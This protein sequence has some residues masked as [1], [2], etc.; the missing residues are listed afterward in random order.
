[1]GILVTC[2]LTYYGMTSV[3]YSQSELSKELQDMKNSLKESQSQINTL[4][5]QVES[6]KA[7][8]AISKVKEDHLLSLVDPWERCLRFSYKTDCKTDQ[9]LPCVPDILAE[10]VL[11]LTDALKEA[12]ITY[13]LSYGTLLGAA[14]DHAIIPW[15]TDV[16]LVVEEQD[17]PTIGKKLKRI[18]KLAKSG[19][20]FFYDE[21]YPGLSRL[22]ITDQNSIF[23][24]YEKSLP[25]STPY[26]DSGY[27]YVDIY[28]AILQ[29]GY[30]NVTWGPPC[31]FREDIVMP[32]TKIHLLGREMNA[33]KDYD[34]YL[35]QIYGPDYK[36]PPPPDQRISHGWY[37][38]YCKNG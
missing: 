4:I 38:K 24:K 2:H 6:Y 35:S 17:F 1:M 30:Y 15:T 34:K 9:D 36:T 11:A 31:R 16:D 37:Q 18:S 20:Q 29:G 25:E 12:N 23:S 10:M 22:C 7:K 28:K 13:W 26:Y 21:T 3:K 5:K 19:Y 33:P 8:L 14:R 32:L 27:P